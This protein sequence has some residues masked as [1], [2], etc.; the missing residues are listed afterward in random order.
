MTKR[1]NPMLSTENSKDV[2]IIRSGITFG[3]MKKKNQEHIINGTVINGQPIHRYSTVLCTDVHV[4]KCKY[5]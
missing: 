5:M 1:D 3:E 4:Q 2:I